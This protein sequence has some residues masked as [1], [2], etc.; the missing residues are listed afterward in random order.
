MIGVELAETELKRSKGTHRRGA[1]RRCKARHQSRNH[2]DEG[3]YRKYGR[4]S[5]TNL[6]EQAGNRA[7]ERQGEA[8]ADREPHGDRRQTLANHQA[9]NVRRTRP[10]RDPYAQLTA[11]PRNRVR[12]DA[13][14]SQRGTATPPR[15]PNTIISD[16]WKR[17]S[18]T[19]EHA[20]YRPSSLFAESPRCD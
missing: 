6:K 5:R 7:A 2:D 8:Q 12:D 3:S 4:L 10:E 13:V 11:P 9:M 19:D 17:R 20:R 18:A 1:A 16:S 14:H 15:P